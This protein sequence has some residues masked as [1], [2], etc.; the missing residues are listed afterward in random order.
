MPAAASPSLLR[1]ILLAIALGV[2]Y[3]LIASPAAQMEDQLT[4]AAIA[5]PAPTLAI[6]LLWRLPYRQW[7]PYLLAVFVSMVLVGDLDWLPLET[8]IE[9]ALLNVLEIG[10]CAWLGRRFVT[11]DG[12]LETV[13]QLM[14]FFLLLPLAAI[15]AIAVLGATIAVTAMHTEWWHEWRALMVGNGVAVLVLVPAL[16]AWYRT[17][18][19]ERSLRNPAY[20]ATLLGVA[21]VAAALTITVMFDTSEEVLRVMLSLIMVTTAIY[22]GVKSASITVGAAAVGGIALTMYDFGPYRHDGIDSVWRLQ[23]DLAGLAI[24]SFFVAIAV[25]ERQQLTLRLE[26]ARRF[27]SLGLLAGG[28]AHDFNNVLGAVGGYAEMAEDA[29]EA[30]LPAQAPLR[31]VVSAVARGKELTEQILLAARRGD[32]QRATLDLREIAREAVALATPLCP[33]QV[34]ITLTMPEQA[35]PVP[36]HRNQ[37]IRALLNLVRNA[38][39]AARSSVLVTLGS[40]EGE[41]DGKDNL[42]D[43]VNVGDTPTGESAWIDIRDDGNG[44]APEHL[45]Q[46]FDPFFSTKTGPGGKGTGLGLAIVAGVATEHDGGVGVRT[47]QG[48]GTRF[49]FTLPLAADGMPAVSEQRDDTDNADSVTTELIGNG[50]RVLLLEDD[51]AQR[52]RCEDW[53]AE[54]G[55]EP[56]GYGDP[57]EGLDFAGIAPQEIFLLLTDLDMPGVRGDEAVRHMRRLMPQLPVVMCSGSPA[58]E[59]AALAVDAVALTKPFDQEGLARAIMAAVAR[60]QGRKE[61]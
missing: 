50:E 52:E 58:L 45:Q 19:R 30:G 13:A 61:E 5:W 56:M 49:R 6:A 16:L 36:A 28:I 35:L 10:L 11:P 14:R 8:D 40:G 48:V 29:L 31:E 39:Q 47:Q 46:L 59:Q 54:L 27:E 37:M 3:Y 32:R 33:P 12:N 26:Q 34:R 41:N 22:G 44:I 15:A 17:T 20:L 25:R 42:K 21:A 55:F 53:L 23:V 43:N 2:V 4:L 60:R 9:F 57:Q 51:R 38:S 7:W 1:S 18:L 24:L